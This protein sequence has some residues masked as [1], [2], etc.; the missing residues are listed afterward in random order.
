MTIETRHLIELKDVNAVEFECRKCHTKVVKGILGFKN[1]PVSCGDCGTQL[2][3]PGSR[4]F[5]RL[6]NFLR[7]VSE[8]AEEEGEPFALRLEIAGL[9]T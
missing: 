8:F 5:E 9:K 7:A 3:I 1:P 6:T 4:E 2:M